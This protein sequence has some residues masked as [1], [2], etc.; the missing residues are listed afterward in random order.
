MRTFVYKSVLFTLACSFSL[1]LAVAVL[2]AGPPFAFFRSQTTAAA[3]PHLRHDWDADLVQTNVSNGAVTNWP[4]AMGGFP[5][6]N[7]TA[8][9][10][11]PILIPSAINGHN[12][13][14]GFGTNTIYSAPGDYGY[15]SAHFFI[16]IKSS[17]GAG[18]DNQGFWFNSG[19]GGGAPY[20][21]YS[22]DDKIYCGIATDARK[23]AITPGVDLT[24]WH[25]FEVVSI[26]GEW[27]CL[28]DTVQVFTSGNTVGWDSQI[29][30]LFGA[31]WQ[32]EITRIM[33]RDERA[34]GSTL[35]GI[36][37]TLK[38]RYNLTGMP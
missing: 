22:G 32:G 13:L 37:A 34:T 31:I 7:L 30:E 27:T 36:Y 20:F 23:N 38:S 10:N 16:V 25:L 24:Q 2:A 35:S 33:V 4:D 19:G 18:I 5:W 29:A 14:K 1:S 11:G 12:S 15:A 17:L 21:T 9:A 6:T 26:A 28:I 8:V 3:D